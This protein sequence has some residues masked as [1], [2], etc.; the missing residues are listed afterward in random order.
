V[1]DDKEGS[2]PRRAFA[3][4]RNALKDK[5]IIAEREGLISPI[6]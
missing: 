3:D 2:N 5:G 4:L 6:S 1:G